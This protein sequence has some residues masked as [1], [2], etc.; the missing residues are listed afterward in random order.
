MPSPIVLHRSPVDINA[1]HLTKGNASSSALW[2]VGLNS[3][4]DLK[5]YSWELSLCFLH[6]SGP[7]LGVKSLWIIRFKGL[8][9]CFHLNTSDPLRN[10]HLDS[11]PRKTNFFSKQNVEIPCCFSRYKLKVWI[12]IDLPGKF[13]SFI[14][15]FSLISNKEK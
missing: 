12:L 5:S 11:S 4:C 13:L 10:I 14:G 9:T 1:T 2:R 15:Y 7:I 8:I 3:Y 6:R